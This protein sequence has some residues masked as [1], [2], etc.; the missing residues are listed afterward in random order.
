MVTIILREI[1]LA[2]SDANGKDGA[3]SEEED[4]VQGVIFSQL[5]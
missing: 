2:V 5:K 1:Y 3:Q 4:E